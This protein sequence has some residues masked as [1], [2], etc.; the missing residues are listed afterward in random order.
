[1]DL[2]SRGKKLIYAVERKGLELPGLT[3]SCLNPDMVQLAKYG[4][5]EA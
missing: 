2:G 1:M 5:N 4:M 3:L